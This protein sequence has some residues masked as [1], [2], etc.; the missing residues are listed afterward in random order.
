MKEFC[1]G[2]GVIYIGRPEDVVKKAIELIENEQ[3]MEYGVKAIK[4]VENYNGD[5]VVDEFEGILEEAVRG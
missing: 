5:D 4:F 3:F 1:E 2:H